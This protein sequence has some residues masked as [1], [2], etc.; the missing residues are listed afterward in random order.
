M[1]G[2]QDLKLHMKVDAADRADDELILEMERA[3]VDYLEMETG[4]YFG[5]VAVI[6]EALSP[7]GYAPL[8]LR[9]APFISEEYPAP[10][11]ESRA[12]GGAW[13]PEA[14]YEIEGDRLIPTTYWAPGERL[15][16]VTYSGGYSEGDGPPAVRAAVR[17]LVTRMYQTRTSLPVADAE[18]RE[19]IRAQCRVAV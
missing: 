3:A 5:P 17:S 15:I 9:T 14:D 8:Y 7:R 10:T 6:T 18:V 12:R 16:R 13:G 19:V 11:V 1:I 4:R 2:L